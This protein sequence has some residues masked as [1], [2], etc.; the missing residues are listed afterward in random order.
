MQ[1][2]KMQK[3]VEKCNIKNE[4]H[5]NQVFCHKDAK[6]AR[7]ATSKK[8]KKCLW[9]SATLKCARTC[10]C[11]KCNFQRCQE[12]QCVSKRQLQAMQK[13]TFCNF[14]VFVPQVRQAA[15]PM[16]NRD[17]WANI[18]AIWKKQTC[19]L[20]FRCVKTKTEKCNA[21]MQMLGGEGLGETHAYTLMTQNTK[22][23]TGK[24]GSGERQLHQC[25]F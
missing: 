13:K 12:K 23:E 16:N 2:K 9:K 25:D 17:F 1:L 14:W 5:E 20:F 7:H 11:K 21:K 3:K 18:P 19:N 8:A 24:G 15:Q 4:K 22:N 10:Y 6:N